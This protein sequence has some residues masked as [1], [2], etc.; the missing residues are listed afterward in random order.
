MTIFS[1]LSKQKARVI[2]LELN[3]RRGNTLEFT[4]SDGE[5]IKTKRAMYSKDVEDEIGHLFLDV[6]SDSG[7]PGTI[8]VMLVDVSEIEDLDTGTYILRALDS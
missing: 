2:E 5:K 1:P 4:M 6:P 8:F 7:E 3:K